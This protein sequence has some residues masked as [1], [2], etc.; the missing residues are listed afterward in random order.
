M[1]PS[2][3]EL[4]TTAP[5]AKTVD[6]IIEYAV[7][8]RASDI[9]IEPRENI[10]QVRYRIDGILH[11]TMTLPKPV[12][13]PVI[14][15]IKELAKLDAT[16]HHLPQEGRFTVK[17]AS[18]TLALRVST[19]PV[20]DGEKVVM[21]L[22]DENAHPLTLE[23]L[24]LEGESLSRVVSG[25]HQPHGLVL[26]SGPSGAGK[27]TTLYSILHLLDTPGVNISTIEDP[28]E[29]RLGDINQTSVD[30]KTGMTLATGLRSLLSQD[31]DIVMVSELRDGETADLAIQ[32]AASGHVI[33][34]AI[35]TE[36]TS[37][38]LTRL[39]DMGI[40]PFLIAS[41]VRTIIAQ[42]LARRICKNCRLS[43]VPTGAELA[44]I[45]RD[46]QLEAALRLFRNEPDVNPKKTASSVNSKA[47]VTPH[48]PMATPLI[49]GKIK[50]IEPDHTIESHKSILERI[51][52]DPNIINRSLAQANAARVAA[53]KPPVPKVGQL[54]STADPT[55]LKTG[56][57]VLYKAGPGCDKCSHN[58][59][60]G[61]IGLFEVMEIEDIVT[62]MIVSRSRT[63]L[64]AEAAVHEGMITMQQDGL[65]KCLRGETTIDE[66][67][68]V[69]R[70]IDR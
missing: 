66:V 61:R 7:K 59:Y 14:T 69:T 57:F 55:Q 4:K 1:L 58:G 8:S 25:I 33:I 44:D 3:G 6:V 65:V 18:L 17:L 2:D 20:L 32:G 37:K 12:L 13:E 15:H 68:R 10:V 39:L 60:I 46:F 5:T 41:S 11:E 64:I 27:S 19:L 43:Y 29:Y 70:Q 54:A 63:D 24:G 23:D 31:P 48:T 35:H 67:L 56:E 53:S 40:E 52:A 26:I 45:K 47:P 50:V 34:S 30:P 38:A 62:K 16:A 51:A 36:N 9:H 42:R 22:L 28:I 49:S 21:R